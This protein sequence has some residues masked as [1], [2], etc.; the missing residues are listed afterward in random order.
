MKINTSL[1]NYK[2]KNQLINGPGNASV[3]KVGWEVK[4]P[5]SV[6]GKPGV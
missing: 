5:F 6:R 4:T 1:L 3:W 2:K